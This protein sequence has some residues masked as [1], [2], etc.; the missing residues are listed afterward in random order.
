MLFVQY[1]ELLKRLVTE[2]LGIR[3]ESIGEFVIVNPEIPPD[4]L[5]DKFCRLDINKSG[6]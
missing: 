2:L 4:F 5:G 6:R 1:Q 3:F